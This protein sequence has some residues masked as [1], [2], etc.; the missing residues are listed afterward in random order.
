LV[1]ADTW[2]YIP[3][4]LGV[5]HW[6]LGG[7]GGGWQYD[8]PV[9]GSKIAWDSD[10]WGYEELRGTSFNACGIPA[11]TYTIELD[12]VPLDF[13]TPTT[14]V[15]SLLSGE[16]GNK[17]RPYYYPWNHLGPYE[18]RTVVTVTV[19]D[20]GEVSPIFEVDLRGSVKGYAMGYNWKGELRTLGWATVYAGAAPDDGTLT[21]YTYGGFFDMYLPSGSHTLKMASWGLTT[22]SFPV[23]VTE[24][25]DL[26]GIWFEMEQAGIPIP[27]FP[28]AGLAL[29]ASLAASIYALGRVRRKRA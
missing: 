21:A 12:F 7:F 26:M 16:Y 10:R 25:A 13:D 28:V 15:N 24:G 27:E 22:E 23:S 9:T 4:G 20:S 17:D 1:A 6:Q 8:N 18:Q 19:P 11:G 3:K 2:W 14:W 29:V 5:I